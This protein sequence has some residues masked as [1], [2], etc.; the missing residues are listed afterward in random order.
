MPLRIN[1]IGTT[2][3]PIPS[4]D[5]YAFAIGWVTILFIPI[6]P[7]GFSL[8]KGAGNGKYYII[9]K[10]SYREVTQRLRLEGILLALRRNYAQTVFPIIIL[11]GLVALFIM[12]V[13]STTIPSTISVLGFFTLGATGLCMRYAMKWYEII[14]IPALVFIGFFI[15]SHLFTSLLTPSLIIIS[16]LMVLVAIGAYLRQRSNKQSKL[17]IRESIQHKYFK[18]LGYSFSAD[19]VVMKSK[20]TTPTE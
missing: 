11:A 14:V 2:I 16:G 13:S 10:L 3:T 15:L 4:K 9:D 1:G 17:S 8:I 7:L 18:D 19:G 6:I 12:A 20:L 5:A